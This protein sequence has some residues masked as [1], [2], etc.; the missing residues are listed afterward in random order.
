MT[1]WLSLA[2]AHITHE[3]AIRIHSKNK[4]NLDQYE[5]SPVSIGV[6]NR[7]APNIESIDQ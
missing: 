6:F 1:K 7:F 4:L 5:C 2:E 3:S